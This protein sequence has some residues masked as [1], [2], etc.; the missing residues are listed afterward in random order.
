MQYALGDI[1]RFGLWV[2]LRCF[3]YLKWSD[4]GLQSAL[5]WAVQ[6]A[7]H[8]LFNALFDAHGFPDK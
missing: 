3:H 4:A 2:V 1:D 5:A 8:G 6:W 7:V